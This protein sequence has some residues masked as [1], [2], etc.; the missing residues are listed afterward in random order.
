M[1]LREKPFTN[2][3]RK[4]SNNNN[5]KKSYFTAIKIDDHVNLFFHFTFK[6]LTLIIFSNAF[7]LQTL[8]YPKILNQECQTAKQG[9]RRR[10]IHNWGYQTRIM[11]LQLA[12]N[13]Y[14][15]FHNQSMSVK[16]G[17]GTNRKLQI[18]N[19]FSLSNQ[20]R[21]R[22]IKFVIIIIHQSLHDAKTR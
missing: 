3:E 4:R 15:N 14:S 6:L 21:Q 19:S 12:D 9:T 1:F 18:S 10:F 20:F 2:R 11:V 22:R 8:F 7:Q 13:C 16:V 17:K 5:S